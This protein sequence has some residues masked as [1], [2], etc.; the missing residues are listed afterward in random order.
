MLSIPLKR[1]HLYIL[2]G[3]LT[4]LAVML[5][6]VVLY[7]EA[8]TLHG[9][10]TL[11]STPGVSG[12]TT[13]TT[14]PDGMERIVHRSLSQRYVSYDGPTSLEERMVKSDVV[15]RVKLVS[16]AQMVE[17]A[18]DWPSEGETSYR[19]ALE[20][21]F[22][23]LEYLKGSGGTEL[24]GVAVDLIDS[25]TT[26]AE[27]AAG[28][29][30]FLRARDTRWDDREAVVFLENDHPFLPSSGQADRYLLG[31][32]RNNYG[33]DHYTIASRHSTSHLVPAD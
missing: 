16:V 21:T 24:V 31:F 14:G 2:A 28:A 30:D 4:L 29:E 10:L 3:S 6:L 15:A 12:T 22:K 20:Y 27:A 18:A 26:E 19:N 32:V 23:A 11:R 8:T 33:Q 17:K 25:Y 13:V 5:A 9:T 7:I 1:R